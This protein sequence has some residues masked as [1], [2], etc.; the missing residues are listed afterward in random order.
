M[1]KKEIRPMV[2]SYPDNDSGT[3]DTMEAVL[4]GNGIPHHLF[5]VGRYAEESVCVEKTNDG[6]I[7]YDGERG[8]KYDL[9]KCERLVDA[10]LQ[11]FNRTAESDE[12]YKKMMAEFSSRLSGET[13]VYEHSEENTD[14]SEWIKKFEIPVVDR[15][16]TDTKANDGLGHIN[17]SSE[18]RHKKIR[19]VKLGVQSEKNGIGNK[20]E[21]RLGVVRRAKAHLKDS[22]SPKFESIKSIMEP[23][24]KMKIKDKSSEQTNAE[25]NTAAVITDEKGATNSNVRKEESTEID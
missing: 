22:K 7:V 11:V 15:L 14:F 18:G 12:Q 21:L 13:S 17:V 6:W 9:V 23:M 3:I 20:A 5:C 16:P 24:R 25:N 8:N 2:M 10:C 19:K 1:S 4:E